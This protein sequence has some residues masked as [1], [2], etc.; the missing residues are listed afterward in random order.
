MTI[1]EHDFLPGN[2]VR[3]RGREWVVQSDSRRDWLRLRPLSGADDESIALIP[4]LELHPVEPATFD[5]PDPARAGNHA[6]ALLLRDALRLTLRAGAGPFRSFGNIAVEPRGYQLVP[7]LMA[8]RLSTVRLLI[9]DD[10]GIGK[11]IEA[12]LIARELMDRGEIARLAILCPPHLVE[13]WQSELETRF[14]LQA[15]ALTSA[16]A[17]RI[18]RD[19]P[20]GVR[21]FDHHP[22]VV[23]SLD[24]IKSERHREQFLATAPECIIVDEA[25]TCAS[26]GAGKQLRFELLQR[27]ARDAQRHLI[28]LTATPHSGDETAFYNLLSLLDPRF[29]ALQ[30][31]M[32]A[33]DPL[34]QELARHFVQ[35]RRK[36]IVEWQAETHDG[37]GFPRRMKTELTYQLSGEWGAFF[38]AVQDYC[39][40]L[41]ET[42]EQQE[43]QSGAR[44]IW[45]ATLALLRCVASSPAAAVKALTTRLEGTVPDEALLGDERLHDGEAD[46]LSGSDLE[47]PA[48]VQDAAP[49]LQALIADAQ[50][51]S[52]KAGDPKLAA[53]IRHIDLLVKDGYHPVVF[54]RYIATA[55][56]VAEHLKAAFPK[57]TVDAVTGELT[58]E[59]RR[60]RVDE[61][62]DAEQ[63]ILVATDCLS[64]GINLQHLFTAVVHYDLAWNPTRHEQR[65]GRVD[66]FG[67]QADEVRC[68]ML[69]GQ[70]NPVDGFVLN[71]ILKKGEAIQKELG[72]LV[73]MP[74]DEARINQALV[75]AALMKRSD[76]RTLS[77][78][79]AFDFGEPEQLLAP[80]Q[81]QWRD[82]L[83]KAKANRTVF[84]QRRIKPD[85]V[86]PEWHKQQ[87]ALGTQADV[88]RFLQSACVRLGSPL[89]IGR[90]QTARF[91]P[92][93]L[94]EALRQR[95]ADE[96]IDK[97]QIIDFSE[98][99][100]SHPLVGLLAQHLL[101][102]AL[103]GERPLAARCAATLTNDVEVVTTLY[104]LRLRHQLSYVRRREPFQMMAEETVALAV[105]G[106]N[107]PQWLADDGVSRLL[108]CTPSGN[109]PPEAAQREIRTALD[110]LAAHPQQLQA[111][112]QQRADAL[113]ADHQ[114]VREATRDVGQYS[115]SP[116]L[117]VDVMG[118]YVLLPDSL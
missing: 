40:E 16:S 1:L 37:R 92:Q 26:S 118:V 23:V 106:R 77:P 103:G 48:Q 78:Q 18:E 31:R 70:D 56:Y 62:E 107:A 102:D 60:E 58:P 19:L 52:G 61:L 7:L 14:N 3:A 67:Q 71:V 95:L 116:C 6:A 81:A 45:Y 42:V 64:E 35:R 69:Y 79:V 75:K 24:Y 63:R 50:R 112:A 44:L 30:G 97:P 54:C 111:V 115:V 74:E 4:E 80:L 49:R 73:P 101:E 13:Q 47:P 117:P 57:A 11:T 93:H 28:L 66:R 53:L 17:S 96:G 22:V 114:R 89:E 72:V 59:E 27:L 65:E 113:L 85:E 33:S 29:A 41:A 98:L 20:H 10:V 100:R 32:T 51:L 99:H 9:A 43:Q 76:S 55:H 110:F 108:E 5:W 34:R 109:L 84:A 25:H 86:L 104:L 21:L 91:L 2:L 12:G 15:V 82:A 46:D 36:D 88:S 90:K 105:Q 38:D 94:P 39:R 68:T 87:Q 83:E 8:L